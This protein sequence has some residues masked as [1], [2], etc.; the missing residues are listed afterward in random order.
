MKRVP[1]ES[2][3]RASSDLSLENEIATLSERALK[4]YVKATGD[5]TALLALPLNRNSYK[6]L[7]PQDR[8]VS[9]NKA[10]KLHFKQ[11]VTSP[12]C[13]FDVAI[14]CREK[15][16]NQNIWLNHVSRDRS[17]AY[18]WARSK[19]Q[20][21]KDKKYSWENLISKVNEHAYAFCIIHWHSLLKKPQRCMHHL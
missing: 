21:R 16:V 14:E 1:I 3:M 20:C 4:L 8:D 5:V 7:L 19:G 15:T 6:E 18:V 11:A 10:C 9:K 12:T 13:L 17:V 2:S